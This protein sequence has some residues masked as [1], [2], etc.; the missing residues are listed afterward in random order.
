VAVADRPAA[1]GPAAGR[2]GVPG[3]PAVADRPVRVHHFARL[4]LR[5]LRN[6][7]RGRPS[8]V[9]RFLG[10]VLFGLY[11][12]GMGFLL[13]VASASGDAPARL[14]TASYGGAG[15]V[16]GSVL[17]PLVWFGV[18]D[19]LDPARFALL[20]LT[21][22]RLVTGLCMGALVSVPAA[23][24]LVATSGLLVPTARHG[25][26]AAAAAQ[27]VGV[28]AGL[29]LCVAAGRAVTSAFAT[30]LR[31]RRVRDLAGILL[32]CLAALVGPLQL[33]VISAA[34][35]ADW[36]R[37]AAIA[38]VVGWTPL[39]A[40]YTVGIE[41]TEG[42]PAAALA[43]LAITAVTVAGLLWW[44]SRTLESAMVG[45]ADS[46]PARAGRAG[47]AGSVAQLLPRLLPGLPASPFGAIVAREARYWWRDA[48][49][50]ANLITAG[51][52]GVLIPVI[53]T[54][55]GGRVTIDLGDGALTGT[56][57][58]LLVNLTLV[59]VGAFGTS[60]LANQ[61]GFDATAY[62]GHLTVGVP[63]RRE[64]R[65]RAVGHAVLLVPLLLLIGVVAAV[66][67]GDPAAAPASWGIMLAS[68]GVGL[69]INLPLSVLAAYALP[70]SANPFATTTGVGFVKSML[71]LL[72]IVG[73]CA[74]TTP[75]LA[76]AALLGNGWPWVAL[77]V[78]VGY[79]LAAAA[80][81]SHLAGDLLDRRAPEVLAAVTPHS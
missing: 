6:A 81:G 27:A 13:C 62:A 68:Y 9:L 52:I 47:R 26:P 8:R 70:D 67:L 60:L 48:K 46:G 72:G 3:G 29:L 65:A 74:V 40:P 69:A 37:L 31:S 79:G 61:F 5:I 16:L 76:V 54:G 17:L 50:R 23:A 53:T 56:G 33:V 22:W 73:V 44:W 55:G 41:V 10:G 25:G 80:L 38:R 32:A 1:D 12:A 75:V 59:F 4:K 66:L 71:S 77:P 21:R 28:V 11:L 19:T 51:V 34:R 45:A 35:S 2:P 57:S 7:M 15:L 49:R 63:G 24:L 78:G 18:D 30:M 36:D 39:A 14:M 43:K 20:P 58:P 64:L 42:R